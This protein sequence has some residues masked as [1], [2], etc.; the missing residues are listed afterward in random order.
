[1]TTDSKLLAASPGLKAVLGPYALVAEIGRGGMTSAFLALLPNGD[2][3]CR[4]LA[5]KQLRSEFSLQNGFSAMLENEA[6][7]GTR[8]RHANVVDT[9]DIYADRDLCVLM[10][11][12][13]DGQTLASVRQRAIEKGGYVPFAVHL[14]V[15]ADALAGLHYVHE[16]KD[17]G[18]PLGIVHR[19]VTP[20]NIFVTYDGCVKVIDFAIANAMLRH[21]E[22]PMSGIVKGSI[23]YMSPEAVRREGVDRRTDIFSVGVMLWEAAT[24]RRLWQGHDEISVF[25]RLT[26]GDLPIQTLHAEGTSAELLRIAAR[27]LAVDPSHRYATAEEMRLEIER[28]LARLGSTTHL[29]TLAEYMQTCFAVDREQFRAVLDEAEAALVSSPPISQVTTSPLASTGSFRTTSTSYDIV[30]AVRDVPLA[31]PRVQRAIGI[32]C[33]TAMAAMGVALAAHAPN[34]AT[35]QGARATIA[36]QP[37]VPPSSP[38]P[39]QALPAPIATPQPA[40]AAPSPAYGTISAVFLVRP[41]H[42]RLFLDG[43]PLEGNPAGIR[44]RP[45]DK[46]HLLRVEAPGYTTLVRAI[47]LD[48]DVAKEFELAPET[49]PWPGSP[50]AAPSGEPRDELPKSQPVKRAAVRDDPWGI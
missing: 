18:A 43:A 26:E 14:R 27:A 36:V 1:M 28:V 32:A 25:R 20:S 23:G 44:R 17:E 12:F 21:V 39:V 35:A 3:T 8:F 45:D 40:P 6:L 41:P 38:A 9:Y 50:R 4:Q 16:L 31:R 10:M 2:G 5:L 42:A 11:E 48:R 30:E 37:A 33:L 15:L 24:G 13:L 22:T 7:L 47:D 34:D 49:T 29:G 46:P 19:N